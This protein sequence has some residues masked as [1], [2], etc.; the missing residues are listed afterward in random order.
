M[1]L[2]PPGEQTFD[3]ENAAKD[4]AEKLPRLKMFAEEIEKELIVQDTTNQVVNHN[5]RAVLSDDSEM[6]KVLET[7]H[8]NMGI[9]DKDDQIDVSKLA[10]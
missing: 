5:Y 1:F 7:A 2:P 3:D 8:L 4:F 10:T 6:Q 9:F